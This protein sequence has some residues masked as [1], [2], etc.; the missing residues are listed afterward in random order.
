MTSSMTSS[1]DVNDVAYTLSFPYITPDHS[2]WL[3]NILKAFYTK[4]ELK[5]TQK[6]QK[7]DRCLWEIIRWRHFPKSD[8]PQ[9]FRNCAQLKETQNQGDEV[10]P[11]KKF[12]RLGVIWR[13]NLHFERH[14]RSQSPPVLHFPSEAMCID[15]F[16]PSQQLITEFL[17]SK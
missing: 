12:S 3:Q 1:H 16:A 9:N 14:I 6:C 11:P 4:S 17:P 15:R 2:D 10:T 13:K 7:I 8:P 5:H